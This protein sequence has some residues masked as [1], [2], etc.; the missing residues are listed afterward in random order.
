MCGGGGGDDEGNAAGKKRADRPS[1][2]NST[3]LSL[4]HVISLTKYTHIF[5]CIV[6]YLSPFF[7]TL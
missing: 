3:A 4:S 5:S 6:I 2:S 7:T 1:T